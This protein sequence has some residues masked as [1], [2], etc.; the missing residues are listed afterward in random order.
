VT[1]SCVYKSEGRSAS[2][3]AIRFSIRLICHSS[4]SR[5]SRKSIGVAGLT[6][7]L[8]C[9]HGESVRRRAAIPATL[10]GSRCP[11]RK[12][13]RLQ[14]RQTVC[15]GRCRAKRWRQTH[16]TQDPEIRATLEAISQL[17]QHTLGRFEKRSAQC[18]PSG[19]PSDE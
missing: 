17:V 3:S 5:R 1:E 16:A 9:L 8:L 12:E 6:K 10:V 18:P 2:I 11:V 4:R 15:S 19:S 13:R 14:G 7:P